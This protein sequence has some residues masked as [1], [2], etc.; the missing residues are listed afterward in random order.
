MGDKMVFEFVV[1]MLFEE[2][3]YLV[4]I[5][6]VVFVK[7]E[8]GDDFVL[9]EGVKVIKMGVEFLFD[10]YLNVLDT[11]VDASEVVVEVFM[12]MCV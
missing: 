6:V 2:V 10:D 8:V 11:Y 3:L 7:C 4:D 12:K 9:V 5:V 1:L